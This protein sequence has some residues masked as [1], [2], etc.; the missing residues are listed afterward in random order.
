MTRK[1]APGRAKVHQKEAG[2]LIALSGLRVFPA[3]QVRKLE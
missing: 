3:L 2:T 1:Q